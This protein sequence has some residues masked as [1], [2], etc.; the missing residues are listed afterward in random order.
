MQCAA[1][2]GEGPAGSRLGS[3]ARYCPGLR[4][5]SL[6]LVLAIIVIIV[7]IVRFIL[8]ID[9]VIIN[10][11]I[12]VL[13]SSARCVI[14]CV[15]LGNLLSKALLLLHCCPSEQPDG[16]CGCLRVTQRGKL[17]KLET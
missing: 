17:V 16:V 11:I 13:C 7:F 1:G 14:A 9:L 15:R 8:A 2:A 3:G 4:R 12:V 10:L 6:L 5:L